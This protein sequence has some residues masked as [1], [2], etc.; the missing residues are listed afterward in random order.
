MPRDIQP[1]LHQI[2]ADV[3]GCALSDIDDTARIKRLKGWD[4]FSHINFLLSLETAFDLKIS[5]AQSIRL[6]TYKSV[7]KFLLSEQVLICFY[8]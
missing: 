7:L 4:S 2:R 6:V 3:F 5:P 1:K 8:C